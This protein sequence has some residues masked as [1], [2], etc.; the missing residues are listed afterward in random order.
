MELLEMLP[1][2]S[3]YGAGTSELIRCL[4]SGASHFLPLLTLV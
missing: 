2:A 1:S 4:A 3:V